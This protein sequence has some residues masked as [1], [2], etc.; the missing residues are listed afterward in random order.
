MSETWNRLLQNR[1]TD[2]NQY[3]YLINFVVNCACGAL[4]QNGNKHVALPSYAGNGGGKPAINT[5][6]WLF[7][8]ALDVPDPC[9]HRSKVPYATLPAVNRRLQMDL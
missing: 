8:C 3:E 1:E 7:I 9:D 6:S 2:E 5:V 4:T